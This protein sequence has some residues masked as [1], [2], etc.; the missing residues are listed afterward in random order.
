MKLLERAIAFAA[1]AHNTRTKDKKP[2]LYDG[3]SYL[4]HLSAVADNVEKFLPTNYDPKRLEQLKSAAWLHDTIEDTD[5]SY[6]ELTLIFGKFIADLVFAVTNEG[7]YTR[8]EQLEAVYGKIQANRDALV[9]KL[10]D[11]IANTEASVKLHFTKPGSKNYMGKY[12]E[13]YPRFK[14]AMWGWSQY[15]NE[16]KPFWE[17][18]DNLTNKPQYAFKYVLKENVTWDN[19]GVEVKDAKK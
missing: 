16:L 1:L 8:A 4:N 15:M 3:V 12:I 9:I 11:R 5:V 2:Q 18:L 19:V 10:A 17:H 13:E 7:S 14:G 6:E